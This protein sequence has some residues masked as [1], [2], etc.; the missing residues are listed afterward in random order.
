MSTVPSFPNFQPDPEKQIRRK[1][2]AKV[3][4]LKISDI[5]YS[6]GIQARASVNPYVVDEYAERM[7]EGVEFPPIEVYRDPKTGKLYCHDGK[8]RTTASQKIGRDTILANVRPG[9]ERDAWLA[10]LSANASHGLP[11]SNADKNR[12]VHKAFSDPEVMKYADERIAKLCC[13]SRRL[14]SRVRTELGLQETPGAPRVRLTL[15][16]DGKEKPVVV[17]GPKPKPSAKD[18]EHPAF[19]KGPMEQPTPQKKTA[20]NPL[21]VLTRLLEAEGIT[22]LETNKIVTLGVIPLF[23]AKA[24]TM[25]WIMPEYLPHPI[26]EAVGR[27]LALRECLDKSIPYTIVIVGRDNP[28]G[29]P[30]VNHL[31]SLSRSNYLTFRTLAD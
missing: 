22:D 19:F 16:P 29:R 28:N 31:V 3:E 11:R 6:S 10:S 14:V 26:C 21:H 7:A 15:T 23:S 25:W 12:A 17:V 5:I 30:W 18:I 24:R 4:T 27:M 2:T 20:A 13:V 1:S 9:T 8:H